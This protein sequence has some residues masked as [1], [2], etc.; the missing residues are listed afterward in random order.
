VA[1]IDDR[2]VANGGGWG[3]AMTV[4]LVPKA[5][6]ETIEGLRVMAAECTRCADALARIYKLPV[7][8]AHRTMEPPKAPDPIPAV[9]AA[10]S[11]AVASTNR[12]HSMQLDDY[13]DD[14]EDDDPI[15]TVNQAEVL[16]KLLRLMPRVDGKVDVTRHFTSTAE[17]GLARELA[18]ADRRFKPMAGGTTIKRIKQ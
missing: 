7:E 12:A 15:A 3:G 18:R 8:V 4:S 1:I 14:D 13:D 9:N 17:R 6:T 11:N 2:G 10:I 5:I 16:A